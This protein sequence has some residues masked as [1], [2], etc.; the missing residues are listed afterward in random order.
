[1]PGALGAPR[2]PVGRPRGRPRRSLRRAHSPAGQPGWELR[3]GEPCPRSGG[4]WGED[5][6]GVEGSAPGPRHAPPPAALRP[7]WPPAQ[8]R[9]ARGLVGGWLVRLRP[10]G[11]ALGEGHA[12]RGRSASGGEARPRP[13]PGATRRGGP[14]PG[15]PRGAAP[16]P[17][18]AGPATARGPLGPRAPRASGPAA[19]ASDPRAPAGRGGRAA[20]GG[21]GCSRRAAS[22]SSQGGCWCR[23]RPPGRRP[24]RATAVQREAG[25]LHGPG[26]EGQRQAG[27]EQ[28][29]DHRRT[30][31]RWRASH[32]GAHDHPAPHRHPRRQRQVPPA[33]L[34]AGHLR[35]RAA[36]RRGYD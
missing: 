9:A 33:C 8:R 19:G 6:A 5:V 23:R 26:P 13:R 16:P 35:A 18:G 3:R 15:P 30:P 7:P 21:G 4:G 10:Q 11:L 12:G 22:P 24:A 14:P 29:H 1:M 34:R 31:S 27:E 17:R 25:G 36:G 20:S 28:R 32:T 2:G